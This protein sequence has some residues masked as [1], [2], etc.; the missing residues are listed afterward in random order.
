VVNTLSGFL[1]ES[2]D[3]LHENSILCPQFG[4]SS[5]ELGVVGAISSPSGQADGSSKATTILVHS[6]QNLN[7]VLF[8]HR[9]NRLP[10]GGGKSTAFFEKFNLV[11]SKPN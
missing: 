4:K 6:V 9:G 3:F 5:L 2:S 8:I 10:E 11:K 7:V 1:E